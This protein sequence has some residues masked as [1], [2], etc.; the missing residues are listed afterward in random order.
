MARPLDGAVPHAPVDDEAVEAASRIDRAAAR[1]F[2]A[3]VS[4]LIISTLVVSQS[5]AALDPDGTVA[6]NSFAAGTVSLVD[7]DEG[8]SLVNLE[9]MAPGRPVEECIAVAY[10]GSIL[11]V[12]L[13]LD[14]Q[15]VGDLGP[16]L[17]VEIDAGSGGGFGACEGFRS[18]ERIFTG[19][20]EQLDDR[21]VIELGSIYNSNESVVYRFTFELRDQAGA[22]GRQSSLDFVW[23]ATP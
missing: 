17:D 11:P 14:A 6:G 15:T 1:A 8:R 16:Y 19:T 23:E 20:L 7:D 18:E 12:A 5:S 4:A 21:G 2:A 3:A 13:T 10:E 9:D 22:V